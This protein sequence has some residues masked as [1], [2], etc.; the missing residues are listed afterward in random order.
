MEKSRTIKYTERIAFTLVILF[1]LFGT[2]VSSQIAHEFSHKQDFEGIAK[3]DKLCA[4]VI[5]TSSSDLASG[6]AAFYQF[7]YA[8]KD[9][10]KVE[11]IGEYTEFKA[12]SITIAIV[13]IFFFCLLTVLISRW[14][15]N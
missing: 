6:E 7:S 10:S 5:P 9:Q 12:Y 3:D 1:A 15:Y 4:L 2:L 14:Y 13:L 11:E 8:P